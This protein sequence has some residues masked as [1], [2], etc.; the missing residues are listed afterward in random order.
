[1]WS[2]CRSE[3]LNTAS[4]DLN[5]ILLHASCVALDER[6]VLLCGPSGSGKSALALELMAR[7]AILVADDKTEVFR[8]GAVLRAR[9]PETISGLIEAR[10]VGLLRA[11]TLAQVRLCVVVDLGQ[12]ETD[13]LP[14]HLK[15]EVLGISLPKVNR[16]D[17]AHFPAALIQYVKGGALD[18]ETEPK[19]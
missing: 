19:L 4:P 14:R 17:G 9:A 1:M 6:G 15:E 12:L 16:I 2:V 7:G 18:P 10:G 13:R 5:V 8:D 11:E 3:R